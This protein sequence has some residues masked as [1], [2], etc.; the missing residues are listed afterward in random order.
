MI[1]DYYIILGVPETATAEDIKA[2]YRAQAMK[3]H[4]DRNPD[5]DTT[6]QMKDVNEAYSILS[7]PQSRLRYDK[8]YRLFKNA[9]SGTY[10][11]QSNKAEGNDY[12]IHDENLKTDVEKARKAAEEYVREFYSSLKKDTAKAAKGAWDGAKPYIMVAIIMTIIGL[13]ISLASTGARKTTSYKEPKVHLPSMVQEE[14]IPA[15]GWIVYNCGDAFQLSVPATVELRNENDAYSQSLRKLNL[16]NND[17]NIIFQQKG[18]SE[19]RT[20][21]YDKY[22]RIMIQYFRGS[23]GDYMKSTERED[24]NYEWKA[25]FDELVDGCIGS[26]SRLMGNYSYKWTVI[27]G[28][29][30]IQIDYKRTGHNFDTSIPVICRIAIFQNNNEMVKIILSYREKEADLWKADF[31]RVFKSFRWI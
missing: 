6:N 9:Y 22:C 4:P 2:A 15:K 18:L 13:I 11:N 28:A 10:Q 20:D 29:N 12:N 27:N 1:K 17:G 23:Y 26:A 19:Q 7:N 25:L 8:E 16:I 5:K 30:C 14:T 31:E 21:A 3:W 24:L